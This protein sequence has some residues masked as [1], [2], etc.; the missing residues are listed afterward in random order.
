M[1]KIKF[2]ESGVTVV[3]PDGY[4]AKMKSLLGNE[5]EEFIQSYDSERCYGLRVNT[6]KISVEDFLK[7]FPYELKPIPW[8][9]SGFYYRKDVKPGKHP[10]HAAGLYYIQEPSAMAVVEAVSPQPGDVVLDISAAPG[11][12]TTQIAN[13]I[14]E[15]GLLIS[16]E[17]NPLRAKAL[18]ENI[19]RFGIRNTIVLNESPER[20]LN[21][22][23]GFFDKV[24][25]D[26]PCSGE[27]MFRKDPEVCYSWSE[28]MVKSCSKT[29]ARILDVVFELLKPGGLLSYST[30]TFSPEENEQVIDEFLKKHPEFELIDVA[31]SRFF[32]PGRPDWNDGN[33]ELSKCMR[34]WPHKIEGEGHFIAVLKKLDGDDIKYSNKKIKTNTS[35]LEYFYDFCKDALVKPEDMDNITIVGDEVYMLPD[36]L[37]NLRGLKVLRYGWYLGQLKK[38]R[39]EP[40]HAMALGLRKSDVVRCVDLKSDSEEV[41]DYLRGQTIGIPESLYRKSGWSLVCV[42]G[43]PLGWCKIAGGNFKNHYPKGLRINW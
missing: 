23:R 2:W 39:F 33:P 11:G 1:F 21:S 42:D 9:E 38:A 37:P 32:S 5:Y 12:K 19:E 4:I 8:C 10:Y 30:C 26:A 18:V 3:L 7:I 15:K 36:F 27:G 43:F 35:K 41:L 25:V 40:S 29:Q 31:V 22:F 16:N 20:L 28:G 24:I 17:I 34:L 6:S 14:G 13:K